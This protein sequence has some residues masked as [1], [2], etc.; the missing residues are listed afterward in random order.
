VVYAPAYYYLTPSTIRYAHSG[1]TY[2][3]LVIVM[4]AAYIPTTGGGRLCLTRDSS[5]LSS[6]IKFGSTVVCVDRISNSI[7]VKRRCLM[8]EMVEMYCGELGKL[9]PVWS[10]V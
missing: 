7:G 10:D 9:P 8:V 4:V 1:R 5:N 3:L 6:L 2:R